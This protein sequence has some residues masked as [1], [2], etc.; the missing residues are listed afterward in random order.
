MI[1]CGPPGPQASEYRS[2]A[3][4]APFHTRGPPTPGLVPML[5]NKHSFSKMPHKYQQIPALVLRK[6]EN[7]GGHDTGCEG[8]WETSGWW[9]DRHLSPPS[10]SI[11]CLLALWPKDDAGAVSAQFLFCS[12]LPE[13]QPGTTGACAA[14]HV[15][16]GETFS[17]LTVT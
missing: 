10:L 12:H 15:F 2:L 7:L 17:L 8:L 9:S 6:M 3:T 16:S 5:P 13:D 1:I 4:T 14:G 11:S